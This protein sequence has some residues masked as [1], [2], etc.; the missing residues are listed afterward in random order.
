MPGEVL[1]FLALTSLSLSVASHA[2]LQGR[3]CRLYHRTRGRREG[4]ERKISARARIPSS[5][6]QEIASEW[7]AFLEGVVVALTSGLEL[8]DALDAASRMVRGPLRTEMERVLLD[9][10]T[11]KPVHRCLGD[12]AARL[13][14]PGVS[15]FHFV[16]SQAELLGTPLA[17]TCTVLAEEAYNEIRQEMEYKLNALPVK[18]AIVTSVL[19]LPPVVLITI[20]PGVLAF[21][22]AW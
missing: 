22:G 5:Y 9:V 7:P 16:L 4:E 12:L 18:L 2:V 17:E 3:A 13:G 8:P 15:R 6:R 19:L 14:L 1:F 21:L 11:G 10:R 20:A